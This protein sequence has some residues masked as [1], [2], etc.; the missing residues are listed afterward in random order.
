MWA[1]FNKINVL[2]ESCSNAFYFS[3]LSCMMLQLF[4]IFRIQPESSALLILLVA[5][6]TT[7]TQAYFPSKIMQTPLHSIF[8]FIHPKSSIDCKCAKYFVKKRMPSSF[9]ALNFQHERKFMET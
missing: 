1:A 8:H 6:Y 5:K 3:S 7:I 2:Q 4:T 9:G